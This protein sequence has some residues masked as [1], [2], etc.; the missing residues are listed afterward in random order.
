M[1]Y[2]QHTQTAFENKLLNISP[3]A[4]VSQDQFPDGATITLTT[5]DS[6]LID[7]QIV[8]FSQALYHAEALY[9]S[10]RFAGQVS[11]FLSWLFHQPAHLVDASEIIN[12]EILDY[13]F[14]GVKSVAINQIIASEKR[15]IDFDFA[16][17]PL[18]D[19]KWKHWIDI[20]ALMFYGVEFPP[21]DLFQIDHHYIIHDG[22]N[23]ISVARSLGQDSIPACVT[24]LQRPI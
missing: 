3:M 13:N 7:H 4:Y 15:S 16:F 14:I 24:L 21:V 8:A 10:V 12:G 11:R 2:R 9:R 1:L 18:N 6:T 22:H 17:N 20:A 23:R 19:K 5:D